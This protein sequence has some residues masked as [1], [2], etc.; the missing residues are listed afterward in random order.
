MK[1]WK[2]GEIFQ[3]TSDGNLVVNVSLAVFEKKAVIA[4]SYKFTDKAYIKIIPSSE[5][6]LEIMFTPIKDKAISLENVVHE[7]CNEMIN[8]QILLDV[9]QSYGN[10]RELIVKQAFSPIDSQEN[11]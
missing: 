3:K 9:E 1:D 10:I 8:Q 6:H 2:A 5:L 11:K 4:S 7:F